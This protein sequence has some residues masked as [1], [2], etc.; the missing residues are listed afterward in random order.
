MVF[1][2]LS[3][4]DTFITL[5]KQIDSYNKIHL[6]F[7]T[8]NRWIWKLQV[9]ILAC[10]WILAASFSLNNKEV[11]EPVLKQKVFQCQHFFADVQVADSKGKLCSFKP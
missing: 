5:E 9:T 10:L 11:K 1:C 4:L 3:E 6:S 7:S 8:K 2:D